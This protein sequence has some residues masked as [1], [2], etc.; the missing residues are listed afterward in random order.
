MGEVIGA[1]GNIMKDE[2][3]SKMLAI[4]HFRDWMVEH[5][6]GELEIRRIYCTLDRGAGKVVYDEFAISLTQMTSM[7]RSADKVINFYETRR[8]LAR[9]RRLERFLRQGKSF[10][11]PT[12]VSPRSLPVHHSAI[13]AARTEVHPS[14]RDHEQARL[15]AVAA[16]SM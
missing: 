15:P 12:N 13:P 9:L 1:D 8:I 14:H 16:A 7:P 4:T 11:R 10:G 5:N 3:L 2:H 6:L